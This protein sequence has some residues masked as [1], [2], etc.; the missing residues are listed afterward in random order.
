MQTE[1]KSILRA[2]GRWRYRKACF[3]DR[4]Y[5]GTSSGYV[6]CDGGG[7]APLAAGDRRTGHC[8]GI[9]RVRHP[10]WGSMPAPKMVQ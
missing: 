7:G 10:V 8:R 1:K 9:V 5:T 3:G 6:G 4:A 2:G